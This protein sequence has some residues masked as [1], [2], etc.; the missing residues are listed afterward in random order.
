MAT[1]TPLMAK[2]ASWL[3]PSLP[4]QELAATLTLTT[5]SSG[6]LERDKV[7]EPHVRIRTAFE[8]G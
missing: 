5:T 3:T 1:G 4:D 8:R 2:M 7:G 6:P